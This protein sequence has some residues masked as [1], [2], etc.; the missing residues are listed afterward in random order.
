MSDGDIPVR[1]KQMRHEA[2][3]VL[4]VTFETLNGAPLP[5]AEPGAHVDLILTDDLRRSYSL[6]AALDGT[7]AQCTVAVHRDPKS[8]GGSVYVHDTMRVGDKLRLSR[9]KNHFALDQSAGHSVLIAGGIGITPILAM[10]R[11]LTE[12]G[13]PWHLHYA[14]RK[15]SA[16]AFLPEIEACVAQS[17]GQGALTPHFDDE[18]SGALIDLARIFAGAG[19]TAHF[20]CCGPEPMLAAYEAAGR[21]VPKARVHAEYFSAKEEVAREGGFDVVLNRSGKVLHVDAGKTILDVLIANRVSVPF[22]CTEGTCG[23]CETRVIEGRPDHRDT[24][25]TDEERAHGDTMMV[26]CSGSKSARLVLDL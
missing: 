7:T 24:I 26:C 4:S 19:D 23:T 21:A 17:N 2:D 20:Y 3:T 11:R 13:K 10:V 6:T 16:A 14:A 8:K 1:V 25:L 12:L 9:P 18:V 15:R 5:K 22:A